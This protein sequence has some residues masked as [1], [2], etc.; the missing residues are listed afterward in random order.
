MHFGWKFL[1]PV[2]LANIFVMSV[3]FAIRNGWFR[4]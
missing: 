3:Y 1:V 2:S 4:A